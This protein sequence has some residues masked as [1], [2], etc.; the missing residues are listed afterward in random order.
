[1][2]GTADLVIATTN[3]GKVREFAELLC[4]PALRLY[5]LADFPGAAAVCEDG[6]T[7]LA[8][9]RIKAR[10]AAAHTGLP[11]LADDSGLEVVALDGAPGVRSARYAADAGTGTGDAANNAFLL[12]C[13]S[14]AP[15]PRR[16]ARFRCVIVVATP[17]GR[18]LV[19]EGICSG[20][21]AD[22]PRGANGFGYDPLFVPA[23]A[24]VTFAEMSGDE[25][26]SISH[27]AAACKALRSG[28]LEFLRPPPS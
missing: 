3:P 25:K 28:L 10:A 15:D 27:R 8:N 9:A 20:S 4:H 23:G 22:R 21:I 5:S 24:A 17:D 13:L 14:S 19:G 26:S 2:N 18:E 11:A 6:D 12:H 16:T 1:M 7:Y